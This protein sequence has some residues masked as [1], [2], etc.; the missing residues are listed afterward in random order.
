MVNLRVINLRL[1]LRL[2]GQVL[3]YDILRDSSHRGYGAR[4]FLWQF[5]F[6]KP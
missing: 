5:A 1:E 4:P 3:Q 2:E 6:Q